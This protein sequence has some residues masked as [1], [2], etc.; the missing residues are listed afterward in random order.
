MQI[1]VDVDGRRRRAFV[2]VPS[3]YDPDRPHSVVVMFQ[4]A[5]WLRRKGHPKSLRRS[6]SPDDFM[7]QSG[8]KPASIVHR[9]VL[10]GIEPVDATH[11]WQA[12]DMD[13]D[14]TVAVLEHLDTLFCL[15]SRRIFAV[16]H[17]EGGLAARR[18]ACEQPLAGIAT[19][20][21]GR[22]VTESEPCEM[23]P[24]PSLRMYGSVDKAVP[25]EG[26][27]GC[28][29]THDFLSAADIDRRA[30]ERRSCTSARG[31]WGKRPGGVC[32]RSDCD[33]T[34]VSCEISGGHELNKRSSGDP[35]TPCDDPEPVTFPMAD[36]A[37]SFF[38]EFGRTRQEPVFG[39][40]A[41][42]KREVR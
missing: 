5:D 34:Y 12:D 38:E 37:A 28:G 36:T 20:Q 13:G 27:L 15:D 19:M 18:L 35:W 26:G 4:A 10:V 25:I 39:V 31:R 11:P 42:R 30:R 1:S 6:R 14:A 2:Y 40:G 9:L 29:L 3:S 32:T 16:G 17:G 22:P 24:I 7:H 23:E 8:F 41:N 21:D 33:T